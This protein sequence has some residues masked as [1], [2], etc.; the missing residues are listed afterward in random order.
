MRKQREQKNKIGNMRTQ[1]IG[2]WSQLTYAIYRSDKGTDEKGSSISETISVLV[3]GED[4]QNYL[5]EGDGRSDEYWSNVT[6]QVEW[7]YNVPRFTR[8]AKMDSSQP[9][10]F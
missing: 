3:N 2:K 6:P 9:A 7:I 1:V 10:V 8:H 5:N 4:S